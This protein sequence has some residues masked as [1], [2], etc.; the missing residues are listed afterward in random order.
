MTLCWQIHVTG[1]NTLFSRRQLTVHQVTASIGIGSTDGI[2]RTLYANAVWCPYK[3]GYIE[4]IEKV[5]KRVTKLVIQLKKLPYTERLKVLDLHTLKYRRIRGDMIEIFKI[6]HQKYDASC[7]LTKQFNNR[8]DTRGNKYKL[9]N[10]SFQYDIRKYSFKAHT[11]NTWISLPNKIVDA[12][13]VNTFKTHLDRYWSDQPLLY[14]F[15]AELAG[16]GVCYK[17]T[18]TEAL[19]PASVSHHCLVLSMNIDTEW[20]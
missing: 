11:I 10:T 15:K 6:I 9:L 5:Q 4:V 12:E 14:D 3:I 8:V 13:S 20:K 18:D 19:V 1:C 17:D 2:V 16:T 7:S